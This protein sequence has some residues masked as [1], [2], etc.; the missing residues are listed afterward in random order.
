MKKGKKLAGAK[1]LLALGLVLSYVCMATACTNND[2]KGN[3]SDSM[4]GTS[5]QDSGSSAAGSSSDN[6]SSAE[7]S[8]SSSVESSTTG[9]DAGNSSST[10]NSTDAGNGNNTGNGVGEGGATQGDDD[11][12][13]DDAGDAIDDAVDDVTDGIDNITDDLTG[14]EGA[15]GN[16]T[17][18]TGA[19][20][21][22]RS[23]MYGN[24]SGGA[25]R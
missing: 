3:S 22:T 11:S 16:T 18:G 13:L 1:K 2:K 19:A 23:R 20:D 4:A 17:N 25:I 14:N 24:P 10:G 5:T 21:G 15:N 8:G 12:L 7:S 9:S 6:G